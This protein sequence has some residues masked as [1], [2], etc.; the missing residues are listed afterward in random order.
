MLY[1]VITLKA[2]DEFFVTDLRS[3]AVQGLVAPEHLP[4]IA[5]AKLDE[6]RATIASVIY[7]RLR[8]GQR[9][10]RNNFV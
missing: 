10:Q 8:A 1:E 6:E 5:E 7:N 4:P 2:R 9:L 3:I